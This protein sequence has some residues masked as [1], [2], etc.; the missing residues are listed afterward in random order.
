PPRHRGSPGGTPGL[1]GLPMEM[2]TGEM[3]A[4]I[5]ALPAK[6][7]ALREAPSSS[8]R[9][10]PLQ[11]RA[12]VEPTRLIILPFQYSMEASLICKSEVKLSIA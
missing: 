3:E 5:V 6:K 9:R 2:T 8:P 4:A 1:H 10:L 12:A 7:E 11:A